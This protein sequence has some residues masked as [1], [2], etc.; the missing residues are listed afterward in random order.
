MAECHLLLLLGYN[1]DDYEQKYPDDPFGLE[2]GPN[3]RV[4]KVYLDEADKFDTE[5]IEG[6][7]DTIDLL[8]IFAGLFSAV[9]AGF[10][11]LSSGSLQPDYAPMSASLLFKL[12]AIQRAIATG[13]SVSSIPPSTISPSSRFVATS[14]DTWVNGL[15]FTSLTLNLSAALIAVLTKSWLS[16]YTALTSG[17]P[18]ERC[19]IRHFELLLIN[20]YY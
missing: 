6:W 9:V 16:Q 8:L 14:L 20:H 11:V 17:T 18:R 4:W 13:I 5:K 1:P 12:V 10:V 19:Q 7:S 15:W 2:A 3:A